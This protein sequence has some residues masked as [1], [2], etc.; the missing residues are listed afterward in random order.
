MVGKIVGPPGAEVIDHHDVMA[1]GN[2]LVHHV[3]PDESAATR[4]HAP[5]SWRHHLNL[6][7]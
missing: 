5:G 1:G 3:A 7:G 2:Q 4:H 6:V